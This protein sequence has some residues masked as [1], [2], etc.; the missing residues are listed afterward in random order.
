M[1]YQTIIIIILFLAALF[2]VGRLVYKSLFKNDGCSAGCGKCSA[3]F[4]NVPNAKK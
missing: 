3:N 4:N 2:Y 1:D